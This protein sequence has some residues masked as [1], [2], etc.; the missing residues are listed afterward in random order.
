MYIVIRPY[1][2]VLLEMWHNFTQ[3]YRYSI[4]FKT[5]IDEDLK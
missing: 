4:P 3:K 5:T 2:E 1:K